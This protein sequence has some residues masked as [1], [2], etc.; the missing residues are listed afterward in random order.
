NALFGFVPMVFK[1]RFRQAVSWLFIREASFCVNSPHILSFT[2]HSTSAAFAGNAVARMKT[3][4]GTDFRI[5]A[6][7]FL[8]L[9]DFVIISHL[10]IEGQHL[11]AGG[12]VPKG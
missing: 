4:S 8:L 2:V 12:R 3:K 5:G 1:S 6:D 7:V 10:H 9:N 11:L